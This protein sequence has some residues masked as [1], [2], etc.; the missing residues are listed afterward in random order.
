MIKPY[1][2]ILTKR[3]KKDG[4]IKTGLTIPYL[5]GAYRILGFELNNI[6]DLLNYILDSQAT[7]F[8]VI[9]KCDIIQHDVI[10][11]EARNV[12]N[13]DRKKEFQESNKQT[14]NKLFASY[15]TN[16]GNSFEKVCA[17]LSA[18]YLDRIKEEKF[19]WSQK[20]TIW[21]KFEP[22]EIE[23]IQSVK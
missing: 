3:L 23:I 2:S 11:L 17:E 19:S 10:K 14:G 22:G 18:R 8:P 21:K 20:D 1:W 13:R 5:F 7:D 6:R 9:E 16:L 4:T 12:A 15:N